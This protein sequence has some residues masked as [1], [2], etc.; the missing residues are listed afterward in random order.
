MYLIDV[1][2]SISVNEQDKVTHNLPLIKLQQTF[3]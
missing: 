3:N 1:Q 2:Y